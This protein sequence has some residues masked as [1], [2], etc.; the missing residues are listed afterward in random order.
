[1]VTA[2]NR[3][4]LGEPAQQKGKK[5]AALTSGDEMIDFDTDWR[6][7]PQQEMAAL[8]SGDDMMNFDTDWRWVPQRFLLELATDGN[9]TDV[10]EAP[11]PV[12]A[13]WA[14]PDL[15]KQQGKERVTVFVQPT[16]G[17]WGERW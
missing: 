5:M 10:T 11:R 7:V 13:A 9:E 15:A 6:W 3:G 4:K 1:M 8:T 12:T 16:P 14:N 17:W 2:K